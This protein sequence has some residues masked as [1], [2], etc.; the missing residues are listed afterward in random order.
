[1]RIAIVDTAFDS[2]A[3]QAAFEA[4]NVQAGAI[5]SFVGRCRAR[6][7]DGEV[8]SLQL[9]HYPGFTEATIAAFAEEIASRLALQ[10]MLIMH[11]VGAVAP[12]EVIVLVAAASA[13]RASA[14]KA[15]E[16]VM[17]FLKTDAPFWKREITRSGARWIEPTELDH[18]R[19]AARGKT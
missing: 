11:R 14:F 10:D 12:A 5:A 8:Q 17:D 19:R 13:H 16:D 6:S 9:E 2:T 4:A 15:V 18:R 3:A 1:M 7:D